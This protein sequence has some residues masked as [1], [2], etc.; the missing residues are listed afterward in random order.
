MIKALIAGVLLLAS[1]VAPPTVVL[2]YTPQCRYSQEVLQYLNQVHKTVPMVN[3]EN[4]AQGKEE[5]RK[6]GG[7]MRVPCLVIDGEPLYDSDAIIRW[8][9]IHQDELD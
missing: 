8:L 3:V 6:A 7:A 9:S 4:N 2:Y 1:Q 5:L